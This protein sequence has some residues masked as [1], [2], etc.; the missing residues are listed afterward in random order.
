M[1]ENNNDD[2]LPKVIDPDEYG[3]IRLAFRDERVEDE[4]GIE[5]PEEGEAGEVR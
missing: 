5:M 1:A 3:T 2:E 4:E